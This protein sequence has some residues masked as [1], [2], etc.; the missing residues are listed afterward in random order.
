M[1]GLF[2][3]PGYVLRRRHEGFGR[4]Y[5]QTF[6]DTYAKVAFAKLYEPQDTDQPPTC[7]NDRVVPFYD[8]HEVKLCRVL[9]DRSAQNIGDAEHH[10]YGLYLALRDVDHSRTK[11]KSRKR[12]ELL[13][14][15]TGP[16]STSSTASTFRKNLRL[17]QRAAQRYR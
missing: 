14:G 7:S 3:R 12:M 16:C 8:A 15:S 9:T 11:T 4:I 17:D 10:G 1:F 13:N 5:Q 2:R 6:I